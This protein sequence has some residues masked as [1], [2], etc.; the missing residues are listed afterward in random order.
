MTKSEKIQTLKRIAAGNI[1]IDTTPAIYI[2][3]GIKGYDLL[4]VNGIQYSRDEWE[5]VLAHN[6]ENGI[7]VPT[8]T[9]IRDYGKYKT[10]EAF[11]I[12][13][14]KENKRLRRERLRIE[15]EALNKPQES[16]IHPVTVVTKPTPIEAE[17]EALLR[18]QMKEIPNSGLM[19][20]YGISWRFS[21]DKRPL[22]N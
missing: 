5:Q 6:L 8:F 3:E 11:K 7:S 10:K 1:T 13:R 21:N 17:I 22:H 2:I 4:T 14:E 16:V 9:C 15:Q 19:S 20:L 18:Q 12:H